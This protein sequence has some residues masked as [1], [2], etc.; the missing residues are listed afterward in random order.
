VTNE[1]IV[2]PSKDFFKM[3][4]GETCI[5][6]GQRVYVADIVKLANGATKVRIEI[7]R[8]KSANV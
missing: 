8:R 7:D 3:K 6:N 2:K 1:W 4:I 5:A